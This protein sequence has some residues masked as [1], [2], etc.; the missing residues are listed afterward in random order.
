MLLLL[1]MDIFLCI[2]ILKLNLSIRGSVQQV[3]M[4][5]TTAIHTLL[6]LWIQKTSAGCL[7]TAVT[8]F[9]ACISGN[10]SS[11]DCHVIAG[12]HSRTFYRLPVLVMP[13]KFNYETYYFEVSR[14]HSNMQKTHR[15]SRS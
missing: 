6:V 5:A 3:E 9:S 13:Q 11:C 12:T 2:S 15:L 10:T 8:S 1:I 7:M 4:V 14:T